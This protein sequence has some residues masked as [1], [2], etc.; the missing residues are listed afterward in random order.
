MDYGRV[1]LQHAHN[2]CTI[3]RSFHRWVL[4][5]N[6]SIGE[7]IT[8]NKKKYR[9]KCKNEFLL[10]HMRAEKYFFML[11]AVNVFSCLHLLYMCNFP[12][13]C[14]PFTSEK[15]RRLIKTRIAVL[16]NKEFSRKF[17]VKILRAVFTHPTSQLRCKVFHREWRNLFGWF[18][19]P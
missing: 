10:V 8:V 16:Q 14:L 3:L 11:S 6:A 4:R 7:K 15:C 9:L 12:H 2:S 17:V 1:I 5:P 13:C 19:A 18:H